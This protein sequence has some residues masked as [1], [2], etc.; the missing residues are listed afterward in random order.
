[1]VQ[2]IFWVRNLFEK[3]VKAMDPFPER[4][5]AQSFAN[6]FKEVW[7][8]LSDFIIILFEVCGL[9]LRNPN[10][11]SWLKRVFQGTGIGGGGSGGNRER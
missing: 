10:S 9:Q 3:L 4:M 2:D 11:S 7:D 6:N 8:F 5:H 1:M